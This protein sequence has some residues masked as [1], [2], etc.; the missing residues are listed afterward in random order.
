MRQAQ[1]TKTRLLFIIIDVAHRTE[2]IYLEKRSGRAHNQYI[3]F[4]YEI[5]TDLI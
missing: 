1:H 4:A 2:G 3:F 5:I